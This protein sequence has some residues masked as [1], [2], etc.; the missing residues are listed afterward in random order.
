MKPVGQPV[1]PCQHGNSG[2]HT[3]ESRNAAMGARRLVAG[4]HVKVYWCE[5]HHGYHLTHNPER[6]R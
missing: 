2:K 4:S 1:V 6:R 5:V 3:F